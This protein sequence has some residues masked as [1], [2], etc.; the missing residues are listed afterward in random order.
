M[1]CGGVLMMAISVITGELAS[2]EPA[3][4]TVVSIFAWLYLIVFGSII[5]FSTYMWLLSVASPAA[6]GTYAYVN[7]IVAVVLGVMVAG[8]TLP[9]SATLAMVV[10]TGSVAL[11]SLAPY[12]RRRP[13]P[14]V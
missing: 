14:G 12:L 5:G 1:I 13:K 2:F 3:K 4:V 9:P 7:P 10:I 11:V 6:V 8:E